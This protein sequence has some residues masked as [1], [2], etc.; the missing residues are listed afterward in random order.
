[1]EVTM[2]L[3]SLRGLGFAALTLACSA[4][5]ETATPDGPVQREAIQAAVIRY[6]Y[7]Q[8]VYGTGEA[9]AVCLSVEA[10]GQMRDPGDRL[11]KRLQRLPGLRRGSECE[12]REDDSVVVRASGE[13]AV[14][15][16]VGRITWAHPDDVR[17]EAS[18][19]RTRFSTARPTYRVVREHDG[20]ISL[21]PI[22]RLDVA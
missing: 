1:M 22:I 20:W 7:R 18:Y 3:H 11:L 12:V 19:E 16:T 17:V 14:R 10:D 4:G 8:F 2:R 13:P 5:G 21:G 6:Q 9:L 15:L